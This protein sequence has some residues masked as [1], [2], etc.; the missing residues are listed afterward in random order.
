MAPGQDT[1]GYGNCTASI[2]ADFMAHPPCPTCRDVPD[3]D[4]HGSRI[5]YKYC[6]EEHL[7]LDRQDHEAFCKERR[8][9]RTLVR[10]A[11]LADMVFMCDRFNLSFVHILSR[12]PG[13]SAPA[14]HIFVDHSEDTKGGH[15]WCETPA[16]AT[17][18]DILGVISFD[19]CI[20]AVVLQTLLLSW[21]LRGQ[22]VEISEISATPIKKKQTHIWMDIGERHIQLPVAPDHDFTVITPTTNLAT[23]GVVIDSSSMQYQHTMRTLTTTEYYRDRVVLG[24]ASSETFGTHYR[25]FSQELQNGFDDYDRGI[26][27]EY[28]YNGGLPSTES[29]MREAS[30]RTI[31]NVVYNWVKELGGID[32]VFA[33]SHDPFVRVRDRLG[34]LLC[35]A[36]R[37]LRSSLD[38]FF[39]SACGNYD[40][41]AIIQACDGEGHREMLKALDGRVWWHQTLMQTPRRTKSLH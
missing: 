19:N 20:K 15:E 32:R 17:A 12:P 39:S 4:I 28:R 34:R 18:A 10:V 27:K 16:V 40:L 5:D 23:D 41:R 9:K 3:S 25:R 14:D 31:N 21:M 36:L 8:L 38:Q 22:P 1:C 2:S 11:C 33:M 6:S 30:L 35:Q 24:S 37:S 26:F 29:Q 13:H 7:V